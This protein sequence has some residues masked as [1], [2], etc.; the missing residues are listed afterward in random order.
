MAKLGYPNRWAR[1][2]RR[3]FEH[4]ILMRVFVSQ[5]LPAVGQY[6]FAFQ[7]SKHY[8]IQHLVPR[9]FCFTVRVTIFMFTTCSGGLRFQSWGS[10][11]ISKEKRTENAFEQL[12][13]H[14]F[15]HNLQPVACQADKT[16]RY[17]T[18]CR[19]AYQ[20][21]SFLDIFNT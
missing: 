18:K 11:S 9:I 15:V 6:I 2:Y 3:S 4:S 14:I 17:V 16:N 12:C 10:S 13:V 5:I 7:H 8:N 19:T 20:C 1:S 21:S